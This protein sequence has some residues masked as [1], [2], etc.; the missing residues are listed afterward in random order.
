MSD[1]TQV[2]EDSEDDAGGVAGQTQVV[3]EVE[4]EDGGSTE[5]KASDGDRTQLVEECEVEDGGGGETQLVEECQEEEIE[6]DSSDDEAVVQRGTTQLVEDSD[7]EMGGDGDVE[8]SQGTQV[9][10]DDE[11]LP[12]N[13]EDVKDYAE[14]SVDSDASTEEEGATENHQSTYA[15]Q[16]SAIFIIS[17]CAVIK[18]PEGEITELPHALKKAEPADQLEFSKGWMPKSHMASTIYEMKSHILLKDQLQISKI[19]LKMAM[20]Q[21]K[22]LRNKKEVQVRQMRREVAQLLDGNQ[23]QT[24]RM[25]GKGSYHERV[26]LLRLI[27]DLVEA[28]CYAD[29]PEWSVD[30]Q[31]AKD[32]QLVDSIAEKQAQIFSKECKLFPADVQIQS[33]YPFVVSA[34]QYDYNPNEDYAETEFKLR[35]HLQSFLETV[36]SFNMIYTKEIHPWTHMMEVPQLHGFGPAANRLLEAYNTLLKFLGNL[37]SL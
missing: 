27:V 26:E 22:L 31:L 1:D 14:D 19:A 8:L 21:I 33:I 18:M 30:E 10:S 23:D 36:K 5:D 25:R 15:Q 29:N 24:T 28:S 37:R 35:E 11:G 32:V 9:Q 6:N 7:N 17:K 12:N 16:L 4:E 20:A 13:E 3:E 34:V 2:V